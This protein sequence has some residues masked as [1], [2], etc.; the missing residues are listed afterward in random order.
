ME[1]ENK[2]LQLRVRLLEREHDGDATRPKKHSKIMSEVSFQEN[3][4]S[5]NLRQGLPFNF[6][7]KKRRRNIEKINLRSKPLSREKS[8]ADYG[9]FQVA[10][11][12]R[13]DDK[14]L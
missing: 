9:E 7:I 11:D 12:C 1:K 14:D 2:E 3:T 13:R 8:R 6:E 4:S 10:I 5:N